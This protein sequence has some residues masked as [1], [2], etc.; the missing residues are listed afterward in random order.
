MSYSYCRSIVATATALT[1]FVNSTAVMAGSRTAVQTRCKALGPS[2]SFCVFGPGRTELA[3]MFA[4]CILV[5]VVSGLHPRWTAA[6]HFWISLS[7]IVTFPQA[8][9]GGD[10]AAMLLSAWLLPLAFTDCRRWHWSRE[11]QPAASSGW[12]A[13]IALGASTQVAVIYAGS[14]GAKL[15]SPRWRDGSALSSYIEDPLFGATSWGRRIADPVLQSDLIGRS[16]TWGTLVVEFAL[17]ALIVVGN[18]AFRRCMLGAGLVLHVAIGVVFGLVSFSIVMCGA[19]LLLGL[20]P[21]VRL[22]AVVPS[23]LRRPTLPGSRRL[24]N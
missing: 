13:A 19:L 14:A 23:K 21:S 7:L 2:S 15:A 12:K 3:R 16:L 22:G 8:T 18:A 4:V 5:V 24:A 17:V 20:G 11:V 9:D 10:A 1:L 6:L